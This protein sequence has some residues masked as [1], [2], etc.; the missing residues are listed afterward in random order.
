MLQSLLECNRRKARHRN[1][2]SVFFL[3][4]TP[5]FLTLRKLPTSLNRLPLRL[6]GDGF[7][8]TP[9]RGVL[10]AFHPVSQVCLSG[11]LHGDFCALLCSAVCSST[12]RRAAIFRHSRR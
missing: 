11:L 10:H 3:F 5:L 8:S 4:F 2:V 1:F 6:R 12:G 9:S 7:L